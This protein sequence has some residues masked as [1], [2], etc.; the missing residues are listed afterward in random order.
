MRPRGADRRNV[1]NPKQHIINDLLTRMRELGSRVRPKALPILHP[2]RK[3]CR[4]SA[5]AGPD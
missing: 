1:A 3:Y 4:Y 2:V 5:S